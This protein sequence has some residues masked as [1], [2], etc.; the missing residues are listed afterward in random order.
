MRI[1][2]VDE[3]FPYPLNTGKRIRTYNLTRELARYNDIS[4]LAFGLE[5][6]ESY[7]RFE[8]DGLGPI[9]VPPPD[10][11]KA[12]PLFYVKLLMNLFSRYPYIVTSH[13]TNVFQRRLTE[14]VREGRYDLVI[15]EWTPYARYLRDLKG[16]KSIVVAHNIESSIWRRYEENEANPIKRWY[17]TIQKNKIVTFEKDCFHWASGATAVSGIEADFINALGVP[18]PTEV[19]D[20]GVDV[21][22]FAPTGEPVDIKQL[23]F[24]GSMDWRPNQDASVYFVQEILPVLRQAKPDVEVVLVGRKPPRHVVALGDTPGVTVTGSVDD[25]RP[26]ISR[27]GVYI[28]PLRIG[29]GSRLKILEA[30][31]MKK[32]VVSTTVG[33]EGLEVRDGENIINADTPEAFAGAVVRLME[34]APLREKIAAAGFDLVH[35][36]YRWEELGKKYDRYIKSLSS[37]S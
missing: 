15:C 11:K 26:Y 6:S 22:Y 7:A 14:L 33:S 12:G 23:V 4:Y 31:A 37:N 5:N 8:K 1:L 30:M 29:G 10:M 9:A 20:N 19:I 21:S 3:E 17:I 18:Y 16:V 32:A 36:K 2:V 28:V 27:S 13:Y 34:D 25:V 35:R 24:T